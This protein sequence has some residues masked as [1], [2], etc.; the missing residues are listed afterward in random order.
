MTEKER[1]K[2]EIINPS[3]KRRIAAGSGTT[4]EDVNKL[5][6]QHEQMKKMFKQFNVKG[7]GKGKR[8]M[9]GMQI[10]PGFKF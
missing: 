10:P 3:R 1:Q 2:P 6:R 7:K 5:L 4:V 8:A 9:R